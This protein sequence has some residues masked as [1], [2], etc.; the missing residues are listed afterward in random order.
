MEDNFEELEEKTEKSKKELKKEQKD[1]KKEEKKLKKQKKNADKIIED[2]DS[3]EEKEGSRFAVVL[4]VAGLVITWLIILVL[5]VKADIGG[6]GSGVLSP[7]LEDVPYI[8]K[9]LPESSS[10]SDKKKVNPDYPYKTVE[11]AI[12]Q[13]KK[14]QVELQDE[15]EK[16]ETGDSNI[17]DLQTEIERLKEFE[18][19][20]VEFQKLKTE[21]YEEVVFGENAPAMKEYQKYYESID[22]TNAELLYKEVVKQ[23][24]YNQKVQDYATTYSAMK[25][26]QA[27]AILEKL[28]DDLKLAAQILEVMDKES[29]GD[30]LGAMDPDFAVKLT[31]IMAPEE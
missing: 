4:A 12:E 9:I 2:S 26:K 19:K 1:K 14:L 21:F 10:K 23:E 30:I 8:N 6:F 11:E 15:K 18:K 31:K 17:Q 22:P 25:P 16:S 13:I 7:I 27:A 24:A 20:Q 28:T 29:R 5:L 3:L